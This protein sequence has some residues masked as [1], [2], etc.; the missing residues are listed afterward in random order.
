ML[1]VLSV[2]FVVC[3]YKIKNVVEEFGWRNG[4][5]CVYFEVW[6]KYYSN[7]KGKSCGKKENLGIG[8]VKDIFVC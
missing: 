4:I 8:L 1:V 2:L 6:W 5:V 3:W 7:N